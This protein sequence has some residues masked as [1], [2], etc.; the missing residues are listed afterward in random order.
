MFNI[1]K[2]KA[3]SFM[4]EKAITMYLKRNFDCN[5]TFEQLDMNIENGEVTAGVWIKTTEKDIEK[6]V[7]KVMAAD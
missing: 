1:V 2:S 5:I 6:I 3:L 7:K 4:A